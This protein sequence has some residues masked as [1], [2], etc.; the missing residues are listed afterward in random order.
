MMMMLIKRKEKAKNR[1]INKL[2]Y[3]HNQ[4]F[5]NVL[6]RANAI[7]SIILNVFFQNNSKAN[8]PIILAKQLS[9]LIIRLKC[10]GALHIIAI[11]VMV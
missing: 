11:F 3:H 10:L 9:K 7:N 1:K 2:I 5:I 4:Q 6:L 8:S